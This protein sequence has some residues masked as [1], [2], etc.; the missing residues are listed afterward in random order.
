MID[1]KNNFLLGIDYGTKKIGISIGQ[2]IT[3]SCRPLDIIYEDRINEI[4]NIIAEWSIE[5]III[6]FPE[7]EKM[8]S[9][10]KEIKDFA[11]EIE[12]SVDSHIEIIFHDEVFTSEFAKDEFA[13]MRSKGITKKSSSDYDDIS[14]SIILQSW[15]NE[16]MIE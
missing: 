6:G 16:N 15:I 12:K 13:R 9:I 8:G 10:H 4:K 3:K 11:A 5:K 7:H 14:A 2:F 1:M